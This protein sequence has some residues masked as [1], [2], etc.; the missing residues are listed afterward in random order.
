MGKADLYHQKRGREEKTA[1][2]TSPDII[3]QQ[4]PALQPAGKKK[5]GWTS[6]RIGKSIGEKERRPIFLL[7]YISTK[8][9]TKNRSPKKA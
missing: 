6:D 5:K 9:K 3:D 1:I 8:K 2:L 4:R 7:T